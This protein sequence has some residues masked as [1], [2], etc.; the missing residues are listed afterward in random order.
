MSAYNEGYKAGYDGHG[1]SA[2]PYTMGTPERDQW[3]KG[4]YAGQDRREVARSRRFR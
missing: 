3:F 1:M 2:C 4:F